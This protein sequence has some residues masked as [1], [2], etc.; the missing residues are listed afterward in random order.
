LFTFHDDCEIL[1]NIFAALKFI[2]NCLIVDMSSSSQCWIF[3]FVAIALIQISAISVSADCA[4]CCLHGYAMSQ[5][6]NCQNAQK[7]EL[8]SIKKFEIESKLKMISNY[9]MRDET[10]ETHFLY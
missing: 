9:A 1:A 2:A 10:N 3:I 5:N 4:S 8:K 7:N 6:M